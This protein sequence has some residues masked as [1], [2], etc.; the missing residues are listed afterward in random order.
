MKTERLYY[1]DCYLTRFDANI[2]D[3]HDNGRRV[4]LDRTAF[5]PTSGGQPNDLGTLAGVDVLD[6]IDEDGRIAHVLAGPVNNSASVGCVIQGCIDW[7]RRYDHMQQHTG[8]HLLSAALVELFGF[9]T[10][11]FHMG[12]EVSTI[13]LATK[14]LTQ[15]ESE[16]VEALANGRVREARPVIISFQDAAG[17]LNLRK[18]SQRSGTL[19]I[20]AI[21]G[22]DRSACGGTHVRST[23]EIGPLQIRKSER[24]RGNVRLEF[25]SGTRALNRSK[26]DLRTLQELA[27]TAGTSIDEL[28]GHTLALRERLAQAEKANERLTTELARREGIALYSATAPDS[29]GI[30]RAAVRV[31]ALDSST[32]AQAQAYAAGDNALFLAIGAAPASVLLACSVDSGIDA[33]AVLKQALS[34]A[35]GRGGGTK[36]IAQGSLPSLE[37][38][39]QI[40]ALL[41]F[42]AQ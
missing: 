17:E 34:A 40:E 28:P 41:G 42:K 2:L 26:R 29:D 12:E 21:E 15:A 37:T 6:V 7:A 1:T 11:S 18:P 14:D 9:Q 39:H 5:Y 32:R 19:R 33:G 36:A 10:V 16:Q 3:A 25:V 13:E 24:I 4:Y 38:V 27:L 20:V 35:G 23:A 31:D 30:R 22:M 8:Q